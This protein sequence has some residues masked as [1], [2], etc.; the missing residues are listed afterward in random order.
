[1]ITFRA[2]ISAE[3]TEPMAELV[4][5]DVP[6]VVTNRMFS[7]KLSYA[8]LL[9]SGAPVRPVLLSDGKQVGAVGMVFGAEERDD[10]TVV[11][12]PGTEASVGF[13]LQDDT[14]EALRIVVLDPRTDAELYRSPADIP[15]NLGVG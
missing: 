3:T 9:G 8:S 7:V 2:V 13:M 11:L 6:T 5:S 12:E 14:V 15:V 4:V 1:M 10:G